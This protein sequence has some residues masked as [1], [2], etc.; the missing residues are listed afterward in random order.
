MTAT[1]LLLHP[2]DGEGRHRLSEGQISERTAVQYPI[3]DARRPQRQPQHPADVGRIGLLSL[4]D[5]FDRRVL[6]RLQHL[7]PTERARP[8]ALTSV[9]STCGAA[10]GPGAP[11]DARTSFRP[12]RLRTA[13]GTLIV[14]TVVS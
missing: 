8:I 12:P 2:G 13:N 6:P 10:G 1:A 4:G 11:S 5:L 9:L 7:L 14:T 3:D